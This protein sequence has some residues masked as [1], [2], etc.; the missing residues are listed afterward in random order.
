MV[1]C[2][3]LFIIMSQEN[4]FHQ[5]IAQKSAKSIEDQ[6]KQNKQCVNKPKII[7][8]HSLSDNVS[9]TA[10]TV[11]SLFDIIEKELKEDPSIEFVGV[12]NENS[13]LNLTNLV[14]ILKFF[15][16]RYDW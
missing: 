4:P 13:E 3:V 6:W 10:W 14:D 1:G 16:K 12:L 11:F 7:Q 9:R 5:K 8:S 2:F 15:R